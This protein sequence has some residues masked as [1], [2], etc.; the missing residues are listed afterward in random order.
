MANKQLWLPA[1][2][3]E[4]L[5]RRLSRRGPKGAP[6]HAGER[7]SADLEALS[8][9]PGEAGGHCCAEGCQG[10]SLHALLRLQIYAK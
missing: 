9:P 6:G 3:L 10:V 4:V 1:V 5:R 7:T 2:S 8:C